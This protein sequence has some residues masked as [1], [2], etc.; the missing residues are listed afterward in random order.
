[1]AVTKMAKK[2]GAGAV[3]HF[4][5]STALVCWPVPP[6]SRTSPRNRSTI[7][8]S[9]SPAFDTL[10]LRRRRRRLSSENRPINNIYRYAAGGSLAPT[11]CALVSSGDVIRPACRVLSYVRLLWARTS[12]NRCLDGCVLD[13]ADLTAASRCLHLALPRTRCINNWKSSSC[14]AGY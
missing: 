14:I 9:F 2:V 4:S 1:M 6:H 7:V 13:Y 3:A 12:F 10:Y 5:M 8:R 11:L